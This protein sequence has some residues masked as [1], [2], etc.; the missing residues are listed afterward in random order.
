MGL[1]QT[2]DETLWVA[3][4]SAGALCGPGRPC[5]PPLEDKLTNVWVAR[6]DTNGEQLSADQFGDAINCFFDDIGSDADGNVYVMFKSAHNIETNGK[7]HFWSPVLMKYDSTGKRL[8]VK[9][10]G[11]DA[12]ERFGSMA[13]ADDGTCYMVTKTFDLLDS[14]E[15]IPNGSIT[16]ATGD[17]LLRCVDSDGTEQWTQEHGSTQSDTPNDIALDATNGELVIVGRTWGDLC[18]PQQGR[19][20]AFL[21][22]TD[23]E[24]NWL[25]GIHLGTD[26]PEHFASVTIDDNGIVI[27]SG[28]SSKPMDNLIGG[29]TA[30]MVGYNVDNERVWQLQFGTPTVGENLTGEV[31][32]PNGNGQ[33]FLAGSTDG[34]LVGHNAGEDDIVL[35]RFSLPEVET[36]EVLPSPLSPSAPT[37]PKP[38][39][40]EHSGTDE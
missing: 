5:C 38:D 25:S 1:V 30:L 19:S 11:G 20:D 28:N 37:A 13:V 17:I 26:M 14:G 36:I 9:Q 4:G 33:L 21:F 35:V 18:E 27:A 32:L 24:G 34:T 6:Y 12:D 29:G 31:V 23:L 8:W 40:A 3:G 39:D 2:P 10:Y 16:N 15:W 7:N 22:R